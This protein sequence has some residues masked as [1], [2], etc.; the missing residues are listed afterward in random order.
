MTSRSFWP[1][2]F[3]VQR[4]AAEHHRL[5]ELG[6]TEVQHL[7]VSLGTHENVGGLEVAVHDARRVRGSQGFGDLGGQIERLLDAASSR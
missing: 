2:L 1:Y 3:R 7:G 6:E 4:L 5:G